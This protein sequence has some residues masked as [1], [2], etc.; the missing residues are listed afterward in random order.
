MGWWWWSDCRQQPLNNRGVVY[1]KYRK[2][3]DQ[4]ETLPLPH[5]PPSDKVAPCTCPLNTYPS[6]QNL[7]SLAFSYNF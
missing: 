3:I 2:H 4:S 1:L 5:H 7:T 6:V